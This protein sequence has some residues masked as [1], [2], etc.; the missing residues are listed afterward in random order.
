MCNRALDGILVARRALFI[1]LVFAGT[2][3]VAHQSWILLATEDLGRIIATPIA[4]GLNILTDISTASPYL[5]Q[6]FSIVYTLVAQRFPTAVDVQPQQFSGLWTEIV[7]LPQETRTIMRL[8]NGRP[9]HEFLLR[10]V[11]AYPVEE[12]ELQLPPLAVKMMITRALAPGATNWDVQAASKPVTIR[13]RSL[14]GNPASFKNSLLVGSLEGRLKPSERSD[15]Q[16]IFLDMRGTSNI[17][18]FQPQ[19]WL[20]SPG[21]LLVPPRLVRVESAVDTMDVGGKRKLTLTQHRTWAVKLMPLGA[22]RVRIDDLRIPVF[23]PDAVGWKEARVTGIAVRAASGTPQELPSVREKNAERPGVLPLLRR[24]GL[25]GLAVLAAATLTG[26][27]LWFLRRHRNKLSPQH[28]MIHAL[29]KLEKQSQRAPR[30]FLEMAHRILERYAFENHLRP[31][32]GRGE[33]PFD[34]C[35]SE[36]ESC[37]FQGGEPLPDKR[38]DI[39]LLMQ[40]IVKSEE[41]ISQREGSP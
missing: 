10:Q 22:D 12:G 36:I 6:Q 2:L 35:W 32:P 23:D 16:E 24:Y 40:L 7:P 8:V 19:D 13:V 4:P 20:R 33:T 18:F 14:P 28:W 1:L 39:L 11:I 27:A 41:S 29:G 34:R 17:S 21:S 26:G 3:W 30:S 31:G 9:T 15:S 38:R 37:R 25:L 5:G